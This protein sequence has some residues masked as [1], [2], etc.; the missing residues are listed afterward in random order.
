M[1]RFIARRLTYTVVMVVAMSVFLFGMSRAAG[2]PRLLYLTEYTTPE[3]WDAWGVRMGLDRPIV[4]QY[5]DWA[6]DA[7]K[8]D[9]GTSL[10]HQRESMGVVLDRIGATLQLAVAGAVFVVL[11]AVPLGILSATR[12]GTV[13]DYAGRTVALMGQSSPQFWL[14]I[15]LIVLFSVY[16]GWLPTSG[17]GDW[18]HYIMPTIT[19]GWLSAAGLLRLVRASMLEAMD[20]EYIR[21]ARAKGVGP[22]KVVWKHGFKNALLAPLTY[23]GIIL[24]GF[25]DGSVVTE[26]VFAWPGVG[27]LGIDAV[28]NNDFPLMAAIITL[29]TILYV[30]TSFLVDVLY[31]VIDPRIRLS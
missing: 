25:I 19:I 17:R 8:G 5:G 9:F 12:R 16:L 14:G 26:T 13:W 22:W 27:R 18:K 20:S 24:A 23:A 29:V 1:S 4:V 10:Q 7:V 31:A 11:L 21:L 6:F 15:M 28:N 30:V 3:E 2:D